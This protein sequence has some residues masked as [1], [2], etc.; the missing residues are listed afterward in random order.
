MI[1]RCGHGYFNSIKVQLKLTEPYYK[2][3]TIRNFN[4][5]KVQLKQAVGLV[6]MLCV[7]FQ[8][9]KG[10]IKTNGTLCT[11]EFVKFISIP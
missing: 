2:R 9:H 6:C 4:S 7:L 5:I 1:W 3:G 11:R 8:F 10:T